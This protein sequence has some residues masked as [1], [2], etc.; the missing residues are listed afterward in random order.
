M[1]RRSFLNKSLV[2]G[3]IPILGSKG[4]EKLES[5]HLSDVWTTK[6][7]IVGIQKSLKILQISDTHISLHEDPETKYLEFSE[8]MGKAYQNIK[9]YK[10]GEESTPAK[11]FKD[12]MKLA[13]SEKV[14]VLALSGDLVNYPSEKDV[15]FVL[16][17]VKASGIPHIYTAGNHDWHYEGMKG[18]ANSLRDQWCK[19]I[20]KPLYSGDIYASSTI[21]NGV[22]CVMLD[23]STYQV[24]EQQL[25]F[26]IH[27]TKRSEPMALFVHI[28]VFV[29]GMKMC[30]GH[31]EWR[32]TNDKNY[33]LEK[34]E[35]WAKEGNSKSTLDFLQEVYNAP[36]LIG[37]FCGH[38]HRYETSS[39]KNMTQYAAM[40]GLNG[41]YRLIELEAL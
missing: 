32:A 22:N 37:V 5:I 39:Y 1:K 2:A 35:P 6:I 4:E 16:K 21:F 24:N 26:F 29:P 20:L 41:Q 19:S 18:S 7:K 38:I 15:A 13:V 10:T 8:R 23:N 14:D 11:C 27:Q 17:E 28:P 34:R 33:K 31:P 9:H 12:L 3:A 40:P 36:N 30:C 25:N